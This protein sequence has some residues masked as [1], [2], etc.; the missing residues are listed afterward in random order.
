MATITRNKELDQYGNVTYRV[1]ADGVYIGTAHKRGKGKYSAELP[2]GGMSR[3]AM[4]LTS[5]S[6]WLAAYALPVDGDAEAECREFARQYP[7]EY[8]QRAM[9]AAESGLLDWDEIAKLF[10]AALAAGIAEVSK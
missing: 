10:R 3:A 7:T 4:S 9:T 2:T 6:D 5:A 8:T 1:L